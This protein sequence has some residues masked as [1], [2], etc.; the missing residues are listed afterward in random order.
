VFIDIAG[1][2]ASDSNIVSEAD[3]SI[4]L[5]AVKRAFL[6]FHGSADSSFIRIQVFLEKSETSC[7]ADRSLDF[8]AVLRVAVVYIGSVNLNA[9]PASDSS[10]YASQL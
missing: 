2:E 1:L 10:T 5:I 4:E 9:V 7:F 8:L 3:E 6:L